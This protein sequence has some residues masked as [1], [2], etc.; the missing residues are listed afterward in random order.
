MVRGE[1]EPRVG[2]GLAVGGIVFKQ[3]GRRAIR[4]TSRLTAC[5]VGVVGGGHVVGIKGVGI[6]EWHRERTVHA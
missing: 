3:P 1:W 6:V 5:R 4:G 2:G